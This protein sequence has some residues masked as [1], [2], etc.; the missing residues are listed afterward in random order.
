M[1]NFADRDGF[2][3]LDGALVPWR[4]AELH[5]L[6]HALHMGGAIFEG[7]RAYDR[8][9]F[10][11]GA[12]YDR[13]A[14][15]AEILG[16]ALPWTKTELMK[17]TE[18]VLWAN[19]LQDCYI[20]PL[21]WRGAESVSV[22]APDARIHVAI[23]AWDWPTPASQGKGTTG[24]RMR[25]ADWRRPTPETAPT[26]SKCSGLYMIGTLARH[27]IAGDGYDDALM[28]DAQGNVAETTATNIVLL[29]GDTLISPKP[30]CFLDSITKHHVFGLAR[31]LGLKVEEATVSLDL[32]AA[33]DEVFVTGTSVEVLP[34]V[35][36]SMSERVMRWPVGEVTGKLM[37]MFEASTRRR[38]CPYA[39]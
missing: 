34:V 35:E 23:A 11:S 21:A 39:A 18:A 16:F 31:R 37:A 29:S 14:R 13:F 10:L 28:L 19:E 32:L 5:V 1:M 25:L 24:L 38:A 33:A 7:I 12:H 20:R 27:A 4:E 2:I 30:D 36:L 8:D 6:T 26:A 22:A 17:A 9:V 15:S 3:W